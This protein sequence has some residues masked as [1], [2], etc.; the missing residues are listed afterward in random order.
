MYCAIEAYISRQWNIL[1]TLSWWFWNVG[2]F[3]RTLQVCDGVISG[4][5]AQQFF[6]RK[7]FRGKDLDIYLPPHGLLPMGCFLKEQGFMYCAAY[8]KHPLFDAAVLSHSTFI[9]QAAINSSSTGRPGAHSYGFTA[10]DLV[11]PK[12]LFPHKKGRRVQIIAVTG[13]P[14]EFIINNFHSSE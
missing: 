14:V 5:E 7:A 1:D 11:R 2:I 6:G 4:S 9:T 13:D 3:L 8:N 10:Y 12:S